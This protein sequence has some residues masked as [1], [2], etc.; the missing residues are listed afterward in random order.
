MPRVR[1]LGSDYTAAFESAK[2]L[3]SQ[4]LLSDEMNDCYI[5]NDGC[6]HSGSNIFEYIEDTG[7]GELAKESDF[8]LGEDG[9]SWFS[10]FRKLA[11]GSL[12]ESD[13]SSAHLWEEFLTDLSRKYHD[14]YFLVAC[15]KGKVHRAGAEANANEDA[16]FE[17]YHEYA[18]NIMN[19][20]YPHITDW[21]FAKSSKNSGYDD[22]Y[23]MSL[24]LQ[25]GTGGEKEIPILGTLY[26]KRHGN[27]KMI[28]LSAEDAN[29]IESNL[30]SMEDSDTDE[31]STI[32][33]NVDATNNTL[34]TLFSELTRIINEDKLGDHLVDC[35]RF[36]NSDKASLE[37]LL[38]RIQNDNKVLVCKQVEILGISHVNWERYSY[39]ISSKRNGS[40]LFS[41]VGGIDGK[42]VMCC[43]GCNSDSDLILGNRFTVTD[44]ESGESHSFT[45][46]PSLTDLGLTPDQ[47]ARIAA[48]RYFSSHYIVIGGA[49]GA[50]RG[51]TCSR[52]L[53]KSYLTSIETSNGVAEFCRDCPYPEIVYKT[54]SGEVRYT[55]SLRFNTES[56]KLEDSSSVSDRPCQCCGRYVSNLQGG[57]YCKLCATAEHHNAADERIAY[58]NYEKYKTLLPLHIRLFSA[59]KQKLCFEDREML[60]FVVGDQKY[61]F[62]KLWLDSDGYSRSPEKKSSN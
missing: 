43:L 47:Y 7:S 2:A 1:V 39:V 28:P 52:M 34:N 22:I 10:S 40:E 33:G 41:I 35:L 48:S 62:H 24:R 50:P 58:I 6:I 55:P 20:F 19:N 59:S 51:K 27:Y 21:E 26:F 12:D 57:M 37:S 18:Q 36:D 13:M 29:K 46:D 25:I 3:I 53:C 31:I 11:S 5:D 4:G 54:H 14:K 30:E 42:V 9:A 60:L 32:S 16:I 49:C 45:I 8:R 56:M 23:G 44:P 61:L 17:L 15:K 38:S